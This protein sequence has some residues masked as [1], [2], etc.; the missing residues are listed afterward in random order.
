MNIDEFLARLH[1]AKKSS[2]G[3]VA[4]CPAHEDK[5][6][7][8]SI[9]EKDSKILLHCFA[10]CDYKDILAK[11]NLSEK[12]LFQPAVPRIVATYDYL[13]EQG[14]LLYQVV[15]FE[16]K[17]FR[18]RKPNGDGWIWTIKDVR[19]V[20]YRLPEILKAKSVLL[21]EGEKDCDTAHKLGITAT[22][23]GSA[24]SKW[25]PEYTQALTGKIVV[26]VADADDP[27]RKH[28][29]QIAMQLKGKVLDLKVIEMP[30]AKDFTEWVE[31]QNGTAYVLKDIIKN[32]PYFGSNNNGTMPWF[33]LA[34]FLCA[35]LP[36]H[37]H[38]IDVLV[39]RGGATLLYAL[40][41]SLK[42]WVAPAIAIDAAS[43]VGLAL[44]KFKI[45]KPVRSLI[46]QV[47]DIPSEFQSRLQTLILSRPS[48]DPSLISVVPR[49]P[50][51][52]ADQFW[53]DELRRAIDRHK[54]E[55]VTLD[56]FRRMFRG[57]VNSAQ[58]TATFLEILDSLR[59]EFGC[60]ILMNHHAKKAPGDTQTSALGSINITAWAD[61]LIQLKNK[62][63][64]G[65]VTTAEVFIES[66]IALT[67]EPFRVKLD[68]TAKE[69]VCAQD[70][71]V[72][73]VSK[74]ASQL[75]DNWTAEDIAKLQDCSV[76]NARRIVDGWCRDGLA[77]KTKA[78][79]HARGGMARYRFLE[80]GE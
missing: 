64:V 33:P 14:K 72:E 22:S 47:E 35:E 25:Q 3:F 43:S 46:V 74:M 45:D 41:K 58:D 70:M 19:R 66:K 20:L 21:V 36:V 13:D 18:Q 49:C 39:P 68:L 5:T 69:V 73:G 80:P 24:S 15:R 59:E 28:A 71:Q 4:L 26:I 56:V 48:V 52:L 10:G 65:N 67:P 79:K 57:E 76:R 6:T 11:L 31:K 63:T 54:A 37:S 27:G 8:L 62:E 50:L 53:K 30:G 9:T 78:G 12:D 29:A 1:G 60:A 7:S 2:S 77:E 61:V 32:A 75:G 42:S 40:P 16:P 38:L 34:D 17:E 44:G 55:L 23:S 51:N